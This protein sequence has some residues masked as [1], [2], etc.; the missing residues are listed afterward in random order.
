M[1]QHGDRLQ[2]ATRWPG[3]RQLRH[4]S[5]TALGRLR[6]RSSTRGLPARRR[7]AAA[8]VGLASYSGRWGRTRCH[9]STPGDV[10]R[11]HGPSRRWAGIRSATGGGGSFMQALVTPPPPS[12]DGGAACGAWAELGCA[13]TADGPAPGLARVASLLAEV[14]LSPQP[15]RRPPSGGSVSYGGGI[16]YGVSGAQGR[17]CRHQAL[18]RAVRPWVETLTRLPGTP[19]AGIVAP[20]VGRRHC[21][22]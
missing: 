1:K 20:M 19:L 4:R 3:A 8:L 17:P 13:P 11:R 14:I 12:C 7:L 5:S 9:P 2:V 10:A 6:G 22:L 21:G 15:Q 16:A 18:Q